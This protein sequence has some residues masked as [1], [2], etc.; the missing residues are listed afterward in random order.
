MTKKDVNE[1]L[2][3]E[4]G[5]DGDELSI[6]EDWPFHLHYIG[7][8]PLPGE[9]AEFYEFSD[10]EMDYY[11]QEGSFF[12][13]AGMTFDDLYLENL[14]EQWLSEQ[15][16]VDLNTSIIGDDQVPTVMERRSNLEA[17]AR[18]VLGDSTVF[19]MVE[20]LFLRKKGSYVALLEIYALNDAVAIGTNLNPISV[21]F[22]KATSYR[23]LSYA[24]GK[25]LQDKKKL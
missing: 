8:L 7:S 14:G 15:R 19:N 25:F 4:F 12:P 16:P 6:T 3:Y 20:G 11:A 24:L 23:R 21:G 10:G 18:K 22:P 13:K 17:L 9:Q 1:Y 5:I 2:F